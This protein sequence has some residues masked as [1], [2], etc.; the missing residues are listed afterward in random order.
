MHEVHHSS[1]AVKSIPALLLEVTMIVVGVFLGLTAENW[2]EHRHERELA[3][4]SLENFRAELRAN[5][6]EVANRLAYHTRVADSI[7]PVLQEVMVRHTPLTLGQLVRRTGFDGT[8]PAEFASTAWDLALATQALSYLDQRLAFDLSAVYKRQRGLETF[9]DQYLQSLLNTNV[10][11]QRDV[12]PSVLAMDNYFRESRR[13][14][15]RL[16]AA[17]DSLLPRVEK[18]AGR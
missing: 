8:K 11:A 7:G 3:R 12:S 5:R 14:E 15:S 16:L 2:R 10:F 9:S 13:E 6:A 18:A 4:T 17:Y 1:H